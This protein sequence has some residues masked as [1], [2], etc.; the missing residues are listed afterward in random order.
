MNS[1]LNR[2]EQRNET[3]C[4]RCCL[5]MVLGVG[6]ES[7]PDFVA[8]HNT[9]WPSECEN[10]LSQR[11]MG[12]LMMS[13]PPQYVTPWL[14]VI[15]QG[16]TARS[17]YHHCVVVIPDRIIDPHPSQSGLRKVVKT[18]AVVKRASM[19]IEAPAQCL[20]CMGITLSPNTGKTLN[21]CWCGGGMVTMKSENL[22]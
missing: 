22:K 10:W 6:Y 13:S 7:V 15:A 18:Y 19:T 8:T 16:P 3:D 2:M 1:T 21:V 20:S 4:L 14:P 12:L 5:A 17:D 9:A 11:R